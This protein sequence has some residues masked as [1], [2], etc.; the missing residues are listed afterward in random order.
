MNR[1]SPRI[2]IG[3][4]VY[5]GEKYLAQAL[6]S[7]LAQTF[8]DFELIISDN[9]STDQT[10][11]ISQEYAQKDMRIRYQRNERNIGAAPNYNRV[12]QQASGEFFKWAA[13]DDLIAPE[14]L[15]KCVEVLEQ[16]PDVI[17]C[18]PRVKLID[19]LGEVR[20][21]YD[22]QPNVCGM[23]RPSDRFREFILH[24]HLALQLYGLYRTA[25]LGKTKLHRSFPSSDE[26]LLSELA[27]LG[28]FYELP[29]RLFLN[30]VHED[31]STMGAQTTQRSRVAWI[32][33]S[34]KG[35]IVLAHWMYFIACLKVIANSK[36]SA[37]D[38]MRCQA[39]MLTWFLKP[40]HFRAMGKDV[41]LATA[42][43]FDVRRYPF[44]SSQ[45]T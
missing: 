6:D 42:K 30:R 14:F 12:F 29:E 34:L 18:Y 7:I 23:K 17:L 28:R 32:D 45:K 16:H 39:V 38:K 25:S 21:N 36:V 40:P 41:L 5:N 2:T 27:L 19:S 26:V 20:E 13:Y 4:P 11:A 10:Q 44:L 24:P 1:H 15:A 3:L 22:P 33:T 35:K 9:A 37:G 8:T 43:L 31:Q